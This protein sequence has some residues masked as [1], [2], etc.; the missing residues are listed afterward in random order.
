MS[1]T[2]NETVKTTEIGLVLQGG[3]ALGAYE[4]GGIIGL[5]DLIDEE[6]SKGHAVTL[7]VV[8]GVSIGAINAACVV[9]ARDRADARKRLTALWD[10]LIITTPP[11][12]PPQ[13]GRDLS[14]FGV[15]H[16]YRMRPDVLL[17]PRWTYLYDTAPLLRTLAG[18]VDFGALN[19]S[20]TTFV[21]TAVDVESGELTRFAN[22]DVGKTKATVIAPNHVLA[23][24]SLPPQFPWTEIRNDTTVHHYWDGGIVDNTPLGDV[25]D[26]FDGGRDV[27]RLIVIMNLFPAAAKL[28][29]TFAEVND[30]VDQLRF[31]NRLRQDKSTAEQFNA[32]IAIVDALAQRLPHGLPAEYADAVNK[33]KLVET[34]EIALTADMAF[35]DPYGFRDFSRDGVEQH[36]KAGRDLTLK[37]L[38][39]RF[40]SAAAAL[41]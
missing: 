16:F 25:I 26:A 40:A 1:A 28:P 34:V 7:K 33:F 27:R 29:T 14:L 38:R 35:N 4:Y 41:H 23:S 39:S 17:M 6:M 22:R 2:A 19:A 37:A 11:F 30:R 32:L 18:R 3:G 15:Q 20:A 10:D 31:G 5:L 36:R 21:I 8:T 9:G 13:I 12:L 24:S